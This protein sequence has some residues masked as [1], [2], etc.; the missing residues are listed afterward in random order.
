MKLL[1]QLHVHIKH[2][3]CSERRQLIYLLRTRALILNADSNGLHSA[4]EKFQEVSETT[5]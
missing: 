4:C 3:T 1:N 5:L 2:F